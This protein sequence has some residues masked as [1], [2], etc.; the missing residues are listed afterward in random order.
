M[1]EAQSS[2]GTAVQ[3]DIRSIGSIMLELMEPDNFE[4]DPDS[5]NLRRPEK[6]SLSQIEDFR[7][8]TKDSSLAVLQ[9]HASLPSRNACYCLL[10]H[11]IAADVKVKRISEVFSR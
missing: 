10:S 2:N 1:L 4:H 3:K 8:A 5:L 11:V 7:K 6:W 9:G